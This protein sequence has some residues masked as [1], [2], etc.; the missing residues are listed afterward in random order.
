MRIRFYL[1]LLLLSWISIGN[2]Q[3]S[4]TWQKWSWL[5]GE[6]HGEGSG[7]PGKGGGRFTFK[8]DLDSNVL[9]RTSH[10]EYPAA[11]SKPAIIHDDLLIVYPGS[12]D[13]PARAIYFDNESHVINYL[14]SF[15][16]STIVLTSERSE[17]SLVF[18]LSY[19]KRT[20]DQV[21]VKFEI[22]RDGVNFM[23]YIEGLSTRNK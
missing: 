6:W 11:A 2:G 12:G 14:A 16:D 20:S 21:N 3:H 9:V 19:Q 5:L 22:S 1:L 18:R 7:Q 4:Q 15:S 17:N 8:Y 23:T 13:K 10:S